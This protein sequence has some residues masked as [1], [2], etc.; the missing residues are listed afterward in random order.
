MAQVALNW[1][2]TQPGIASV[3]LGA[4]KLNQLEDNLGALDFSIPAALRARLE[5]ASATPAPFP[6]S[7]FGSEIQA[8]VTGGAVTGDKPAGY[9]PPVMIEG[10]AVSISGD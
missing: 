2:A 6:H 3:I 8:R 7:Y 1:V 4:T 10:E 5:K 9:S